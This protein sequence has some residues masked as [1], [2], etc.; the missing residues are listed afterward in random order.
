MDGVDLLDPRYV[1]PCRRCH[2]AFQAVVGHMP[3]FKMVS[4]KTSCDQKAA[5]R[6]T[7]LVP[8]VLLSSQIRTYLLSPPAPSGMPLAAVPCLAGPEE[9]IV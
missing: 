4:C 8:L 5:I 2:A 3:S 7:R 9:A 6:A 1:P